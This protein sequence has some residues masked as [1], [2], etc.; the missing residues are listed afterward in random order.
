MGAATSKGNESNQIKKSA[1]PQ[2]LEEAEKHLARR[3]EI[4]S[5]KAHYLYSS[6][7]GIISCPKIKWGTPPQNS[8]MLSTL[9]IELLFEITRYLTDFDVLSDKLSELIYM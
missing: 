9:P 3:R 1:P 4:F 2:E 6:K 5:H 8:G 7:P